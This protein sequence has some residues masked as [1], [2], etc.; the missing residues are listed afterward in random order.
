MTIGSKNNTKKCGYCASTEL[1]TD[2][3]TGETICKRCAVVT[4]NDNTTSD[5]GFISDV[6]EL[7]TGAPSTLTMHDM[8]L[9]TKIDRKNVDAIG[10][11]ITN[12]AMKG[13]LSRLRTWDARSQY[14][15][16]TDRNLRVAMNELNR[17]KDKLVVPEV[18]VEKAAYY[19][20]KALDKRL[21]R[22]RNI[23]VV[24]ASCLYVACRQDSIPRNLNDVYMATNLKKKDIAAC[25]R[26]ILKELD[27]TP[28]VVDS[29]FVV[30]RITTNLDVPEKITRVATKYLAKAKELGDTAGK[31]PM[32]MAAA[33]IYLACI[34]NGLQITQRQIADVANVTEVTIRNRLN[35]LRDILKVNSK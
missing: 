8:G 20:R 5:E 1:V 35:R 17:I 26:L 19:Y 24:M 28:P 16:P 14:H 31:D 3:D 2:Q 34:E 10:K 9:S 12:S 21:T 13:T 29:R 11:P 7:R 6:S 30:S 27:I 33:T 23:S 22:G 25:Y 15:K 32:G 4:S 18:T